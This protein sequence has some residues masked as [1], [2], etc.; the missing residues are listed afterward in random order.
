MIGLVLLLAG[1][2]DIRQDVRLSLRGDAIAVE[3]VVELGRQAAFAEALAIDADKD[4]QLSA[5]E[6]A[7]Y[8]ARLEESIR[9]GLELRVEGRDIPL[10]R[11][12]ELKLEMPFRKIY[13][14]EAERSGGGRVEF[15]NENF[16]ESP[17]VVSLDVEAEAVDVVVDARE[18]DLV[19]DVRPGE[20]RVERRPVGRELPGPSNAPLGTLA[21]ILGLGFV[22]LL[23]TRY[24]KA[25][26]L[27]L[28]ACGAAAFL[29][30]RPSEAEAERIF[31]ALHDAAKGDARRVK[32]LE[33]RIEVGWGPEFRARH[34]WTSYEAASHEGHA[35]ARTRERE[36]EYRV[37]WADGAWRLDE[38]DSDAGTRK[39]TKAWTSSVAERSPDETRG[40]LR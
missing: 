16:P 6:R 4:G 17:G 32:P 7:R 11:A 8:F 2:A 26:L 18:R 23:V 15:H 37:R 29:A 33:T 28:V 1:D 36:A 34:R 9:T 19:C 13:R 24:R 21:R 35:H 30:G 40:F 22:G 3:Y 25:T 39:L 38:L 27:G 12:G 31:L 10:R 5:E 20:G 14:F